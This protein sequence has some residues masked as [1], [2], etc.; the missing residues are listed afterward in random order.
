MFN[1]LLETDK[2][3]VPSTVTVK[4]G[5]RMIANQAFIGN[6]N[7]RTVELPSSLIYIGKKAFAQNMN[8]STIIYHGTETQFNSITIESNTFEDCKTITYQFS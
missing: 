7:I 5:T 1:I 6:T 4:S 8:L 2:T 3:K